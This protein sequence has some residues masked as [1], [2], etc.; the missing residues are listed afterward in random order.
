[1]TKV[2]LSSIIG[3]Q[4]Q[5]QWTKNTRVV[6]ICWIIV[7]FSTSRIRNQNEVHGVWE[8]WK[9]GGN[10][11][12]IA[13][14][15]QSVQAEDN[16]TYAVRGTS[17]AFDTFRSVCFSVGWVTSSVIK[18]FFKSIITFQLS[19]CTSSVKVLNSLRKLLPQAGFCITNGTNYFKKCHNIW[20]D[21]Q[22]K[23]KCLHDIVVVAF[24]RDT[25]R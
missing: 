2:S 17:K 22:G 10:G 1:M 16:M 24:S 21:L 15:P 7:R 11:F 25:E 12:F 8:R 14:Q 3:F 9:E 4:K 23:N 5:Q 13:V 20:V 19:Q 18:P 6:W